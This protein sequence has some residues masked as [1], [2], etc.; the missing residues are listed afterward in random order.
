M[1]VPA[2]VRGWR[3]NRG[4][5]LPLATAVLS[6]LPPALETAFFL[7][8][9]TLLAR[10]HLCL[11][12]GPCLGSDAASPWKTWEKLRA[13]VLAVQGPGHP[14]V[15]VLRQEPVVVPAILSAAPN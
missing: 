5:S 13:M 12:Q 2:T 1:L 7:T 15:F 10:H 9:L 4:Q 11:Q 14:W 6:L 8:V 3:A